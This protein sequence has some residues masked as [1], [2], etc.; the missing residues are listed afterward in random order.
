[1][2]NKTNKQP[3]AILFLVFLFTVSTQSH[4]L[5]AGEFSLT[6]GTTKSTA[7]AG[8]TVTGDVDPTDLTGLLRDG[9][10]LQQLRSD[11]PRMFF[12]QDML[13]R[14]RERVKGE[15]KEVFEKTRK[16]V[17]SLPDDAPFIIRE[18]RFNKQPDGILKAKSASQFGSSAVIYN[19][20]DQ[21]VQAALLYL[22][23]EDKRYL[24][25]SKK[26][27]KLAAKVFNW[28]AELGMWVDWT[29]NTRIN[30]LVAYDWIYNG[31]SQ[32]ERKELLTP[33]LEFIKKE[34]P[35]GGFTFRRTIGAY[36]NGN[37][38]ATA[39]QWFAGLA[40]YGDGIDD[41]LAD[42]MLKAGAR[43]F[44]HMMDYRDE[45]SAGSGLLSTPTVT[46]SFSVY[47]H[48]TFHFLHTWQS[49]FGEDISSRWTQML[50][51]P[52]WFDWAAIRITD[53]NKMLFHGVGDLA[54]TDNLAG[55]GEMYTNLAQ[56]IHFYGDQ[57]PDKIANT[58]RILSRFPEKHRII[59]QNYFPFLPFILSDFDPSKIPASQ[60]NRHANPSRNKQTM[61]APYFFNSNFGLLFMRSG[62]GADDTYASFR[63]GSSSTT[64]QHYDELSFIIY[65]HNFL[66]LDAGSRT[67][68]AH[69]HNFAA[70]S[71][72]HNTILIHEAK[73]AMPYFWRP[74]GF[75][76]DDQTY[77]NHGGQ[78]YKDKA[79][80]IA[81]HSTDDFVYAAGDATA[82]YSE[83]KSNEVVRQFVYV[84]PDIFVVYDRVES[85]KPDQG[86]EFLLHLQN[87][88]QQLDPQTW[89]ADHGGRLFI[90]TLLP[91]QSNTNV[92]GG[93]GKEFQ[94]SGRNWELPGGDNWDE[95]YQLT[96][97][98][99]MEIS[100]A[101]STKRT[102][103][104]HVLQASDTR[105]EQMIQTR[106]SREG[107]Y[108]MVKFTD[109][110]GTNWELRFNS[111]GQVGLS[112]RQT[113]AD[114]E[115]K[116][117]DPLPN[118]IE[119]QIA[120]IPA[121]QKID[122]SQYFTPP[123]EFQGKF[124]DYR[125]VLQFY[126]G[127]QVKTK[128]DWAERRKEIRD[129]WMELMGEWPAVITDQQLE[130]VSST[131]REDFTQYKVRFKWLPNES[132]EGYLL[133]PDDNVPG[134]N[135]TT[136]K[137]P[138]VISVFYEP[139]TAIGQGRDVPHFDFAYQLTKRGFVSLSIGTTEATKAKTYSLYYPSIEN[140]EVEPLSML[141][142]AA[143]NALEALAKR[144][145]VDG[146]KIGIIGL[147]FGGKWSM[148]A[149]TLYDKFAAAVWSDPGIV[150]DESRIAVNYWEP[151]Y[152]GYHPK[153]WRKRALI[154]ED[155]PAQGL[156]PELVK[157]GYDLHELHAL[158]APR[159]F[160][161]SGGSEDP[162]ERWIPLNSTIAV[163]KL[164]G[165]DDRVGMTN[166]PTHRPDKEANDI[167]YAFFEKF[168]M[169]H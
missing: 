38:G 51:Y 61:A 92:V 3:V 74:W 9:R 67:S 158:M 44:V 120:S 154:T 6:V 132:T 89:K 152:L 84:K 57:F 29:T 136:G 129:R 7:T 146:S 151:W 133:V 35:D 85:A 75:E 23:T 159:P 103:F 12:N 27:L 101:Q 113:T 112:I 55:I 156:Y 168:L 1:M 102:A 167:A 8:K 41:P 142:Y 28:S 83:V 155:N 25:I 163:N 88:P 149:S 165:Y 128:D 93:S 97:K 36:N 69:H 50:D 46:Y 94:A 73:E 140:A 80:Q 117:K 32:Q 13:P 79:K 104:L 109:P 58:Y 18:D 68:T 116:F 54:H 77:Y 86:K 169:T 42:K 59:R 10:W 144:P 90:R 40:A 138:A 70:Q 164:L 137:R 47:P 135:P 125:N 108:D 123:P 49:A 121:G 160:L 115:V 100:P 150:F 53:D 105:Q 99:R 22:I 107:N 114:G 11:H 78:A 63:F 82:S 166:R 37:Y 124:G 76:K 31:L 65:K 87:K 153:P 52:N 71:V 143:A 33:L 119:P 130:I 21:A 39:L 45:I 118:V 95:K 20:A 145:E 24:E 110:E 98:W 30:A 15:L 134:K 14:L 60:G 148:F 127:R 64:H 66:A 126:D 162:P 72:A 17:E 81:L 141:G 131:K 111:E 139:E 161:V 2:K 4:A 48:A 96:G 147:S 16:Q 157:N 26:Y 56:T 5:G 91:E 19:G 34:Q 62:Q 122:I 106:Y 43:L